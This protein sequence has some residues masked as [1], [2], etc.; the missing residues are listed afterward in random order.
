M[1]LKNYSLLAVGLMFSMT[2]G[3]GPSGNTQSGGSL[4]FSAKAVV[5]TTTGQT[6]YADYDS[7]GVQNSAVNIQV[8]VR[9]SDNVPVPGTLHFGDNTDARVFNGTKLTH[10]YY[11]EGTYQLAVVP[12]G[13]AAAVIGSVVISAEPEPVTTT[14]TTPAPPMMYISDIRLK[15][16]IHSLGLSKD[17]FKLYQFTYLD[18]KSGQDYVGVM[19]QDLIETHPEALVALE[20]GY[21]GVRYDLLGLKMVTAEQWKEIGPGSVEMA[22]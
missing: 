14:V 10:I 5:S 2:V 16:Q 18:D 13:G 6:V 15:H 20:S 19:A 21:Y 1:K 3:C 8:R 22:F 7:T 11:K 17:G 9:D 4:D 12:D